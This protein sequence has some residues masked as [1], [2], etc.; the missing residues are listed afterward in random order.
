MTKTEEVNLRDDVST[1]KKALL[2]DEYNIGFKQ[3]IEAVED[4]ARDTLIVVQKFKTV[5]YTVGGV[6]SLLGTIIA[7]VKNWEA[8]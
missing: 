5:V 8:L 4:R 1:I 3:R 6:V 2:G 7:I